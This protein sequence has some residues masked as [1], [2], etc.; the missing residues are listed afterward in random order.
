MGHVASLSQLQ[1]PRWASVNGGLVDYD[2]VKIHVSAEA[3]TRALSVFEGLKGYWDEAGDEFGL[4]TPE[5]HY[6]RL[7]RSAA[8]FEIPIDFTCDDY[9]DACMALGRKLLTTEK[10]LW[11]R[12]TLYV[13]DGHWGEGTRADLVITAFLQSKELAPPMRLGVSTWRRSGDVQLPARVKSSANYVVAR[14]AR[15]EAGRHGYDDAVM[16]NDRGRV[17]ES[18]GSCIVSLLD[19]VVV[20]PP[21]SEGALPSHSLDVVEQI[22]DRDG[23]PF[24]RR[25]LERSELLVAEE[26]ALVGTITELT[27]VSEIE[28]STY[29]TDGLLADLRRRYLDVMRRVVPLEGVEFAKLKA[30]TIEST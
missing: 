20:T 23:I 6:A 29:S 3:L 24:E 2:D 25:P 21:A 1:R 28:G 26:V 11:F 10:D 17:A 16:L 4:R 22:C 13:V 19:G 5:R 15:I 8:L 30:S 27:P 12:T 9:V 18:T 14:L 7:C